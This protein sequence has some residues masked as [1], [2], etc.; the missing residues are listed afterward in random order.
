MRIIP[1]RTATIILATAGL[2]A[3]AALLTTGG[4]APPLLTANV[5]AAEHPHVDLTGTWLLTIQPDGLPPEAAIRWLYTVDAGGGWTANSSSLVHPI[6]QYG[7]PKLVMGGF[8]GNWWY[9]PGRGAIAEAFG[10]QFLFLEDDK[11]LFGYDTLKAF[12]LHYDVQG[13]LVNRWEHKTYDAAGS[14]LLT[15]TGSTTWVRLTESALPPH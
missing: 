3:A 11:S 10:A 13:R 8:S 2:L 7:G 1:L 15:L 9:V 4:K 5:G 12:V 6:S 14:L